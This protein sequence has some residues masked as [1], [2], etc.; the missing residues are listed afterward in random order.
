GHRVKTGHAILWTSTK[1]SYQPLENP[2]HFYGYQSLSADPSRAIALVESEKTAIIASQYFPT[3][4]WLATGGAQSFGKPTHPVALLRMKPLRGRKIIL[5]PDGDKV[6]LWGQIARLWAQEGYTLEINKSVLRL[7]E[8]L[9]KPT[10]DIA[11]IL[12]QLDLLQFLK[13][14][15]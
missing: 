9:Q 12:V 4:D 13:K 11:D 5:F 14:P 6:E 10:A 2:P 8:Q 3:M 7:Q 1:Q 15:A